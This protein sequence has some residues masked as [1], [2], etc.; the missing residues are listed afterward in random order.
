MQHFSVIFTATALLLSSMAGCGKPST[1]ITGMVTIDGRPVPGAVMEFFPTAGDAP[2]AGA[3]TNEAGRYRA[4]VSS[5]KYTVCISA[6]RVT[7]QKNVRDPAFP[8]VTT[9]EVRE[10][11]LPSR[12]TQQHTTPLTVTAV[13]DQTTTFDFPLEDRPVAPPQ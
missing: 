7:G 12:Y 8:D 13:A 4:R 3:F 10:Q 11:Y 2:T 9:A 1:V 5:T 6:S